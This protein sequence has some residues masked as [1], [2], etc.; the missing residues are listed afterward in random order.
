MLADYEQKIELLGK[1][2]SAEREL[3]IALDRLKRTRS[4]WRSSSVI[5]ANVL[6]RRDEQFSPAHSPLLS[7]ILLLTVAIR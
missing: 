4:Q 3:V 1:A 2:K 5:V 7:C 6:L